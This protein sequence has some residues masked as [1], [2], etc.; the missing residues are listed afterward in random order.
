MNSIILTNNQVN[1]TKSPLHS[2]K[3][4]NAKLLKSQIEPE[5]NRANG[6][7]KLISK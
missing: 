2:F 1:I 4:Q 3:V 6:E 5:I 7:Q